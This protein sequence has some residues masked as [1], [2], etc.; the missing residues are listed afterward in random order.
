M[1]VLKFG[2]TS[3]G[4]AQRII[5][6]ADI[7][8]TNLE[9]EPLT[10]VLS[11]FSGVTDSL[12]ELS[13][14][15]TTGSTEY[16]DLL[17]VLVNRHIEV[18]QEI[19]PVH[20]QSSLTVQ[21]K[22]WFNDLEDVLNGV[23]LVGELSIRCLD[24]VMSFGELLS[25]LICSAVFKGQ[26]INCA[27]LDSRTILRTDGTF[28][29][30][31][32]DFNITNKNIV[33]HFKKHK[34][35]QIITGFIAST[36]NNDTI[37]LG[38]G[39]SDYTAAII[40]A[41]LKASV[42]EIWTDVDGMMTADPR[43]VKKAFS[44]PLVRYEEAMELSHFGAKVI[45]PPTVQP[46]LD[47]GIPIKVKNTLNP[48]YE[49]TVV[50]N[51]IEVATFAICGISSIPKIALFRIQG[52]GMVGVTGV[53]ARL[54]T[55]L[56]EAKV[57]IILISQASS[58]FSI[59]FAIKPEDA[60]RAKAAIEK[61]FA[62]ELEKNLIE[63]ISIE[64]SLS[65][66]SVVGSNMK[67]SPGIAG[68]VF[69][70]L[71]KNGINIIAIAQGSSE[72]NISAVIDQKDEIKALNT[73]HEEFFFPETKSI[74]VYLIGVG[75]IGSALLDQIKEHADSLKLEH[76]HEIK[77]VGLANTKKMYFNA[78]GTNPKNSNAV[79][80]E[81]GIK[82][83]LDDFITEIK[84]NNLRNSVFVDCTASSDVASKYLDILRSH[85]SIVTPNKK[86]Q[87][88]EQIYYQSLIIAK[89]KREV[90]FLYETSVGAGLPVI[91]TLN[92]L[93][94]SGDKVIKIEAV[95]SG[96]LS[97]IFNSVRPNTNFSD[98][99]KQAKT[100]GFTEP[101][102]REDLNGQDVARKILI[103]A[104]ES[105]FN[106][107]LS[108]VQIE[109]LVPKDLEKV[110]ASEFLQQLSKYDSEFESRRLKA[111]EAGAKL[112]FIA[113]FSENQ[114][115]VGI[116]EIKP[117]H[118]FYN[119]DGSDNIVSFTTKRYLDRPLVVK[120]PGAGAEVTAAGVF[121]DIVRAAS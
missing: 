39:G 14:I 64:K 76:G 101:D 8:K 41:A 58:E 85:I 24:Y 119:L 111:T 116:Q 44:Q 15:A 62:S 74:N 61:T 96:T 100:K 6:V 110:S 77:L 49:G 37:T 21:V 36:D 57:N 109:S 99:V 95:L 70:T 51:S 7:I 12:I 106:L 73:L 5:E 79:L 121:A 42:I 71:G 80:E 67:N 82:Y 34:E 88:G 23:R 17:K 83:N 84:N 63:P 32:V 4:S 56:A 22:I 54:F 46:A 55:S 105:G 59:C 115:K 113:S 29:G 91:N 50:D 90:E 26:G 103:L 118:P 97:Y 112:C 92:D 11:A 86:A 93:L 68:R 1:K 114:A 10:V 87:S 3:V 98:I 16:K 27:F 43:K 33:E 117:D 94:K 108:D 48:A 102:P 60:A 78:N 13:K 20:E 9:Q 19:V 30:G 89:R 104:R 65:V 28:G 45:Y 2:G 66:I 40:G 81:K 53:S 31:L 75:L 38:R 18:I 69:H 52:T 25:G 120:G 107:E 72:L 47:N 35:T